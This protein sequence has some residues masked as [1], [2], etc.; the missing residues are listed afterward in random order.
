[1]NGLQRGYARCTLDGCRT[2][3]GWCHV[4]DVPER[5]LV[6]ARTRMVGYSMPSALAVSKLSIDSRKKLDAVVDT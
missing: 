5:D 4:S 6:S 1:M 3:G 2:D